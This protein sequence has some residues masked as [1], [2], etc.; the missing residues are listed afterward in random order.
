[1]DH[2]STTGVNCNFLSVIVAGRELQGVPVKTEHTGG[3]VG[4]VVSSFLGDF[5]LSSP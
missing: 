5:G 3:N 4:S 1:M 2:A